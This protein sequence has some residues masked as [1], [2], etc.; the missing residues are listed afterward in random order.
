MGAR[1]WWLG[2]AALAIAAA[3][4]PAAEVVQTAVSSR[5]METRDWVY[6]VVGVAGAAA[7]YFLCIGARSCESD[8]ADNAADDWGYGP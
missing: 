1:R 2:G 4:G 7:L 8:Q 3:L 5:S 6:H